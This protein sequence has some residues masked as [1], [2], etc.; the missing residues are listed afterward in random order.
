MGKLDN[1]HDKFFK[2]V[3]SDVVN[4]RTFLKLSLPKPILKSIDIKNIKIDSTEYITG[5]MKRYFSDIVIKTK[6]IG[7]SEKDK[8]KDKQEKK[9]K[10]AKRDADI[11]ILFE[12]KSYQSEKI[13][14]Q[15]LRYMY[16][17]WCPVL[18]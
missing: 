3:F 13:L 7:K 8:E 12:H 4:V 1:I 10:K 14:F 9:N 6:I 2:K 11:Y 5:E 17:M 15:L 16:L 18:K